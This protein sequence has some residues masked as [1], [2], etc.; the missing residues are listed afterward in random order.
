VSVES[1]NFG[2]TSRKWG[3]DTNGN[4]AKARLN[5]GF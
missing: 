4:G 2:K 5:L 1:Q 3:N